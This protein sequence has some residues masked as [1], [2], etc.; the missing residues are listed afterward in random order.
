[1]ATPYSVAARDLLRNTLLDAARDLLGSRSWADV[2]MAEVARAAGVSRQTL[3][4]EFGSRDEFAIALV[5]RE[6]DRFLTDV[7]AAILERIE[8]P[9]AALEAAFELFLT[10]AAEDPLVRAIALGDEADSLLPLVTTQGQPVVE[11]AVERLTETIATGWPQAARAD[12]ELLAEHLV[13]LGI[14]YAALPHGSAHET[15]VATARLLTPFVE[16]AL[17]G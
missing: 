7:E 9:P 13:R 6:G 17:G 12:A 10:T 15:A 3:Y 2:T 4:N 11:R 5:M 16:R 14:S 1:M 8:D